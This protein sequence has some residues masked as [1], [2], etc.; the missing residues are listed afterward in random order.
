MSGFDTKGE[1]DFFGSFED[2]KGNQGVAGGD[3]FDATA[4]QS[5]AWGEIGETGANDEEKDLESHPTPSQD[6][7]DADL[8]NG[9]QKGDALDLQRK[10]SRRKGGSGVRSRASR[11]VEAGVEAMKISDT[12]N[13]AVDAEKKERRSRTQRSG[14]EDKDSRQRK[15]S[16][17][18]SKRKGRGQRDSRPEKVEEAVA[19][20]GAVSKMG[21]T[22]RNAFNRKQAPPDP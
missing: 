10:A 14:E 21:A 19:E 2:S 11:A 5:A 1:S 7:D 3:G 15:R 8:N 16:T 4:F 6:S 13:T 22:F 17:S 12:D 9:E 20:P 18:R